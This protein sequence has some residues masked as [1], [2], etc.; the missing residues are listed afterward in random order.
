M[1]RS[2]KNAWPHTMREFQETPLVVGRRDVVT[3]QWRQCLWRVKLQEGAQRGV[4]ALDKSR[5][6]LLSVPVVHPR[7]DLELG[8]CGSSGVPER[9]SVVHQQA[10]YH[11][12]PQPETPLKKPYQSFPLLQSASSSPLQYLLVWLV[13]AVQCRDPQMFAWR[14]PRFRSGELVAVLVAAAAAGVQADVHRR[15]PPS[16][17]GEQASG[18]HSEDGHTV[19]GGR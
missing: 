19:L 8:A 9:M 13:L 1:A 3:L 11:P 6:S 18:T 16:A 10:D 7:A 5:R 12:D 2:S 15:I 14:C 17:I 4:E